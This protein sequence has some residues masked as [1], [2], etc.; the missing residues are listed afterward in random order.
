MNKTTEKPNSNE[1]YMSRI[2]GVLDYIENNIVK[3]FRM[4]EMANVSGFP[5]RTTI[6]YKKIKC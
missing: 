1:S 2:N 3:T 5:L 6:A 4:E